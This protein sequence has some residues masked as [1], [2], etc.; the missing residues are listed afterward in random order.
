MTLPQSHKPVE[1]SPEEKKAGEIR[2][3]FDSIARRY[4]LLNRLLSAGMDIRWRRDMVR[5]LAPRDGERFLDIAIGTGDVA[6]DIFRWNPGK[7]ITVRGVDPSLEML[8]LAAKK[9]EKSSVPAGSIALAQG[10]AEALP[11][12]DA[13]F[14]GITVAFGVRNF[15]SPAKGLRE[16]FRV[17]KP[18]GRAVVLEFSHP[19]LNP[20]KWFYQLY[21]KNV[22]PLVGG[23]ISGNPEA[24]RYL[25]DSVGAFPVREE[26]KQLL[27]QAGFGN[28]EYRDRT[29]GI[30]TL[31]SAIK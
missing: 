9:I 29:F 11:F 15:S 31:Y 18:G 28:I 19:R 22:L 5:L 2:R 20:L 30:V 3:M 16:M 24:Y 8:R 25:P 10:T 17:L 21:F 27:L 23:W 26:F 12:P 1:N 6:L 7:N 4:D 13:C 14:D